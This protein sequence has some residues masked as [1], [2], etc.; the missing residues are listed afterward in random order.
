MLNERRNQYK[1]AALQ[2]KKAGDVATASEYIKVMKVSNQYKAAALQAEKARDV[3][4]ASE[5]IKVM[6]A[7]I[8][9]QIEIVTPF[10]CLFLI[11][12]YQMVKNGF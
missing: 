5:Y 4:I 1:A 9:D 2:A 10:V 3:A 8:A 6:K 11:S 7:N 12:N